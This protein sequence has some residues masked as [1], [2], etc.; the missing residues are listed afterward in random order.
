M[1][2]QKFCYICCF[3]LIKFML[4]KSIVAAVESLTKSHKKFTFSH[5]FFLSQFFHWIFSVFLLFGFY[6]LSPMKILV[7]AESL[8]WTA[9][10]DKVAKSRVIMKMRFTIYR[11]DHQRNWTWL[12]PEQSCDSFN[13]LFAVDF[14]HR[15]FFYFYWKNFRVN[16]KKNLRIH[17]IA[18]RKIFF[19]SFIRRGSSWT[20]EIFSLFMINIRC[21]VREIQ[22]FTEQRRINDS[23]FSLLSDRSSQL[24]VLERLVAKSRSTFNVQ[25]AAEKCHKKSAN[26]FNSDQSKNYGGRK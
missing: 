11:R 16:R 19:E 8:R 2:W 23:K 4:I 10:S 14:A 3:H 12:R 21:F 15:D 13:S 9:N 6:M 17:K 22:C 18:T 1:R 24:W 25:W 26:S 7:V 20:E 5:I